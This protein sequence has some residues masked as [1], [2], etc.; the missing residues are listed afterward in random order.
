MASFQRVINKITPQNNHLTFTYS[1][2]DCIVVYSTSTEDHEN[3]G[4][5][6]SAVIDLITL[7]SKNT[8]TSSVTHIKLFGYCIKGHKIIPDPNR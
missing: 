3:L 4:V 8:I 7:S 2:L 6:F 1:Y 5:V